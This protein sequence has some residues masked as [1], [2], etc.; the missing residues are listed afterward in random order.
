MCIFT[1]IK[2]SN[3]SFEVLKLFFRSVRCIDTVTS[4]KAKHVKTSNFNFKNC[5][6]PDLKPFPITAVTALLLL[7][8]I[9]LCSVCG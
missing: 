8:M 2:A 3:R 9:V 7:M 6:S 1:P 5:L 4:H